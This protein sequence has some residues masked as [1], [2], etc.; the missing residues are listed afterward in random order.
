MMETKNFKNKAAVAAKNVIN[1][2][3]LAAQGIMLVIGIAFLMIVD[4]VFFNPIVFW[5]WT[6]IAPGSAARSLKN[7][8]KA[9]D[10][11]CDHPLDLPGKFYWEMNRKLRFLLPWRC[12]KEFLR[13]TCLKEATLQQELK[14]FNESYQEDLIKKNWLSKEAKESLWFQI[15]GLRELLLPHM[16][17]LTAKQFSILVTNEEWGAVIKYFNTHTPSEQMLQMLLDKA[18]ATD[19]KC[20]QALE[21]LCNYAKARSLPASVINKLYKMKGVNGN[22]EKAIENALASYAQK[23][24]LIASHEDLKLWEKLCRQIKDDGEIFDENQK[25]MSL[26]QYGIYRASGLKLCEAA[27][28]HFLSKEDLNMAEEI[29]KY[30]IIE[31][32]KG[33]DNSMLLIMANPKLASVFF[34]LLP[35]KTATN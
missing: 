14:F 30:E 16:G 19:N 21:L 11:S 27:I 32:Q 23:Q 10:C 31:S 28:I 2:L 12:K 7:T 20:P 26:R 13:V 15:G 17:T 24:I 8:M 33:S 25:L 1:F 35:E 34:R 6:V 29:I 5:F 3:G 22:S 9:D 18:E 4:F